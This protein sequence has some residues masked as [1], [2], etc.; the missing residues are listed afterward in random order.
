MRWLYI[1]L[2][3][4]PK[5]LDKIQGS[6]ELGLLGGELDNRVSYFFDAALLLFID[7]EAM[8]SCCVEHRRNL[9]TGGSFF[10]HRS[11]PLS[12]SI[13]PKSSLSAFSQDYATSASVTIPG[14]SLRPSLFPS[15][16]CFSCFSHSE[17]LLK[18]CPAKVP[19][20][21][22]QIP[23]PPLVL[24]VFWLEVPIISVT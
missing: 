9:T 20:H 6:Y 2:W 4:R 11:K 10:A 24:P 8:K 5:W 17:L 7:K 3:F 1:V 19:C 12:A 16:C 18:Q 14:N 15:V 21:I 23:V 22:V 13:V